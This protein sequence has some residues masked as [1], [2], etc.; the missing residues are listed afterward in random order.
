MRKLLDED[1]FASVSE[2][3]LEFNQKIKNNKKSI[4]I[5]ASPD[6][7]GCLALAPI[8]ASLLDSNIPYRR[9]FTREPV[10]YSPSIS[11]SNSKEISGPYLKSNGSSIEIL[12][13]IVDG[14]FG[15]SGDSKK[16]PLT[17]ISQAHALA[18]LIC[19]E[20][21]R[22]RRMRPWMISGNWLQDSLDNT[23]DPVFSK[24]K[25]IL[26]E[27]GSIRILPITEIPDPYLDNLSWINKEYFN[28]IQSSWSEL[29]IESKEQSISLLALQVL[30]KNQPSTARIEESIW[31]C[32][33]GPGWDRDIAGQLN[34][35]KD[36]WKQC[37]ENILSNLLIDNLL[38]TGII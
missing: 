17:K 6:I 26:K 19:P 10:L 20:S 21:Q 2:I 36:N 24:L 8:E 28:K 37:N 7:S 5:T 23:Y 11:I 25:E 16:G 22:V 9:R 1:L 27:D 18:D 31:N 4:L 14:L 33:V 12:D 3:Y 32:I 35:I 29:N 34:F 30:S 38:K 13:I 15:I